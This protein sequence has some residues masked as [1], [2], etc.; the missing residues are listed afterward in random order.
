VS[1]LTI[2]IPT[3]NRCNLLDDS[4]SIIVDEWNGLDSDLKSKIEIVISNNCSNDDTEEVVKK[5]QEICPIIKYNLNKLN[6][7][8]EANIELGVQ[9][10]SHRYLW[11]LGDDDHLERGA[12]KVIT[13]ELIKDFPCIILNYSVWD[14]KME[15]KRKRKKFNINKDRNLS[16]DGVM[17]V[18]GPHLGFISMSVI[19]IEVLKLGFG[20]CQNTPLITPGWPLLAGVYCG[21]K[22]TK[23]C[24]KFLHMPILRNRSGNTHLTNWDEIFVDGFWRI[25]SEHGGLK[26]RRSDLR[27]ARALVVKDFIFWRIIYQI[28]LAPFDEKTLRYTE[29]RLKFGDTAMF[30]VMVFPLLFIGRTWPI[31]LIVKTVLPLYYHLKQALRTK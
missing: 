1:L 17:K 11:I 9:F 29:L 31:A 3:Y 20:K 28:F 27:A 26:Y 4:L 14:A 10:T 23:S 8:A 18:F 12:L 16:S 5:Y 2:F 6:L 13:N 7:G 21:L 30:W 24:S 19:D 15:K 25:F 22:H